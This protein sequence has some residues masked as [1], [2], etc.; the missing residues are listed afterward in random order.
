MS[1]YLHNNVPLI[2]SATQ[3]IAVD[4]NCCCND[5][6]AESCLIIWE[7]EWAYGT[8]VYSKDYW[9]GEDGNPTN[10]KGYPG[11]PPFIAEVIP[12]YE[13]DVTDAKYID[14]YPLDSPN[15]IVT[16]HD[17]SDTT[18][19]TQVRMIIGDKKHDSNS[20]V[21]M[22]VQEIVLLRCLKF[23]EIHI[24]STSLLKLVDMVYL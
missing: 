24:L 7:S 10:N 9:I 15:M 3:K 1:I 22:I 6:E 5:E 11:V 8:S 4:E 16:K 21:L 13:S 20:F 19:D 18:S 17:P 14:I 23:K 12:L 2:D